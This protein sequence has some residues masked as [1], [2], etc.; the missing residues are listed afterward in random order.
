MKKKLLV[1]ALF[2]LM[3]CGCAS[4][5]AKSFKK[6]YESLNGK[7]NASGKVHR[8]VKI[9]KDNPFVQITGEELVK[10]FENK[11]TFYVY[12]GDELCP[13]CRSVI[14]KFIEHAKKNG[15]EKV[16]YVKI[17]DK[18]GNEV[19]RDKYQVNENGELEQVFAGTEAYFKI[20][21]YFDNVLSDYNITV[22]E[23]K[24]YA[25]EKRVYAPNFMYVENGVSIKKVEGIPA[26][27]TDPRGELTPDILKEEDRIFNEFFTN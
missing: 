22:G 17:W 5:E 24:V 8:T 1:I 14:E 11:E 16:Y 9:D 3:L 10:K 21:E 15:V 25:N 2:V 6:D 19:F 13:W 20:M 23:D 12:F 18:D 26:E 7:T 27:L 4:K